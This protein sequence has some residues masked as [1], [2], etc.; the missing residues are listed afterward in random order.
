[1]KSMPFFLALLVQPLAIASV[2]AQSANRITQ[3]D[4]QAM[5]HDKEYGNP[6][7][8]APP[9]LSQFAFIIGN[10][11]CEARLKGEDGTWRPYQATWVG[12][13]ILDGYVIA[14]EYR[15]TDQTGELILHGMNFRSYSVEKKTWVM[16][17]LNAT[18][19]WLELGPENLGGVRV[20]PKSITFNFIDTFAP[21]A[22]TRATFSNISESH[23][24]WTGERSLDQGKTWAEFMVIEAHR[25]K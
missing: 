23:F 10:W 6:N 8:K 7:P 21:D 22:A 24:T 5:N 12:R 4:A 15:M 13:Y 14:D 25:T 2:F 18:G 9:E 17:W 11:R 20:S 3:K 16:R 1:M 19:F